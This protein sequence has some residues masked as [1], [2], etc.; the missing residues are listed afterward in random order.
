MT[1]PLTQR[2]GFD[3]DEIDQSARDILL[4]VEDMEL[5]LPLLLL[6]L[7]KLITII[8]SEEEIDTAC[9]LIDELRDNGEYEYDYDIKEEDD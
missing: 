7:C 4:A 9:I 5:P 3:D 6:S 2:Y 1:G 8:G